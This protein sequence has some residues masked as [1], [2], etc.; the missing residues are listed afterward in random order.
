MALTA[1]KA[2]I[3]QSDMTRWEMAA[4]RKPRKLRAN[5]TE[6]ALVLEYVE[7]LVPAGLAT[8]YPGG[9]RI[10]LLTGEVYAFT[11]EGIVRVD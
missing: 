2:F 1:L 6:R 5:D 11:E 9:M 10:R 8:R 7:A 4:K 3:F